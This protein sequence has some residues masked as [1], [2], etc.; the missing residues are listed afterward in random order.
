MPVPPQ[1]AHHRDMR[2][3]LVR[4]KREKLS[5]VGEQLAGTSKDTKAK[6]QLANKRVKG[7]G[8]GKPKRQLGGC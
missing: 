3:V 5:R 7:V 8:G 1:K 4:G 6:E 2:D